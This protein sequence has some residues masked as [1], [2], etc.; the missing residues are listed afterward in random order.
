MKPDNKTVTLEEYPVP[1]SIDAEY[2]VLSDIIGGGDSELMYKATEVL[3]EETTV[4]KPIVEKYT[5]LSKMNLRLAPSLK[6][7]KIGLAEKGTVVEVIGIENDWLKLKDG[8]FIL[9]GG[10]KFAE[11]ND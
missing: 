1:I 10:G 4:E 3:T 5:L 9:Y 2:Q 7:G 8:M 11:K 6:G